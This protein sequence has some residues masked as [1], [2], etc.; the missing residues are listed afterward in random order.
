MITLKQAKQLKP[1]HS[2]LVD[3]Q[4]YKGTTEL[5][6]VKVTGTPKTWK[7]NPARIRVPLKYGLYSYGELTNGT[8][9]GSPGFTLHLN[10]VSL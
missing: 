5:K 9:E 1:G 10:E 4:Y 3:G 6:R 7:R 8:F 2:L